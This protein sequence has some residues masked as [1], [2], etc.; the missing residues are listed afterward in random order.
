MRTPRSA[1]ASRSLTAALGLWLLALG[2]LPCACHSAAEAPAAP[3]AEESV[4]AGINESFLDPALSIDEMLERFESESREIC[5]RRDE[6][7][8]ALALEP[9]T[10]L[11]DVGAGTGLFLEPFALAVGPAG[12]VYAVD[13]SPPM[14]AHMR[15]RAEA[16]GWKQVVAVLGEERSVALPARSIDAAFVC[17][18]YHHF[19]YPRTMLA[20][21]HAALRPGGR[22]HVVDFER[23]EGVSREWVLGHVRAGKEVVSAEIE[24]AGFELE[25]EIDVPGLTENYLLSFRRR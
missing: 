5:A 3:Q 10:E 15:Q 19:E 8:A 25:R 16:A 21:L 9:G 23:I 20:S 2:A 12:R 13:I 1:R 6:I 24:A 17:D 22:L 18:T 4:R 11:A 14:V 7:V